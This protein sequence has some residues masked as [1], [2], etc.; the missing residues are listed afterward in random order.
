MPQ[1]NPLEPRVQ[2]R[3]AALEADGLLRTLNPPS[4]IDLSSNDYL[5]LARHP[6]IGQRVA[7]AVVREGIGSTGSRLL[8]GDREPFHRLERRFAEFKR[9]ERSLYFGAGYLANLAVL[10]TLPES[11]DV[12]FSDELNHASL[13]DGM[14]LSKARTVV[15]PHNDV[16]RLARMLADSQA[17][18]RFVVVESLFSMQG[19]VAP[20]AEYADVCRAA[21]ATLVVDE[22]HAVGVFGARGSGR[23]ESAGVDHANVISVNTGGK[24]LGVAGACVA[25][26]EW[27]I[28][29]LLQRG[30]AFVFTTAPPPAFAEALDASLDVIE[31]EPWRR[32]RVL[33]LSRHLRQRLS[34]RDVAVVPGESQIVPVM[35][36]DNDRA[37]AVAAILQREGFDVRAI[38]PPS[39][40]RGTARLR[41]SVNVGLTEDV[42][43][44]FVDAL[45]S[46]CKEA[47][48][49]AA[50]SS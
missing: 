16:A 10:S 36:G 42:L 37:V 46:A 24:A 7:D 25:G 39:V 30:R 27:A 48:P 6:A 8:R 47:R 35:L 44:R 29:Y 22:A 14:R 18:V 32:E 23:L 17:S 9:A 12:I 1:V 5:G 41:V 40:P 28:E 31:S 50:A 4:G 20:L 21:G 38:R 2:A 26:P 33:A 45:V 11:G 3:L 15:F 43:D 34:A 13:I 19:D 49:C